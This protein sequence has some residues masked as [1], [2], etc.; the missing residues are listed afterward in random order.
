MDQHLYAPS[1]PE[2]SQLERFATA[3][4]PETYRGLYLCGINW[5]GEDS[6]RMAAQVRARRSFFSDDSIDG[7]PYRTRILTW[8]ALWGR[9]LAR[10]PARAGPLERAISQ[11]NWL[12]DR[13]K[14]SEHRTQPAYLLDHL[15]EF[16]DVCRERNPRVILLLG[17]CLGSAL[18]RALTRPQ[19]RAAVCAAFGPLTRAPV[20]IARNLP[21]EQNFRLR[22]FDFAR[23]RLLCLPH[24]TGAV[25]VTNAQIARYGPEVRA[26]LAYWRA[27]GTA[28]QRR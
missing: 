9:P 18:E 5:G 14:R 8:F 28:N 12:S 11:T 26:A 2:N 1:P 15:D 25:G 27:G 4:F 24:P 7:Y 22:T 3:S 20:V 21:G 19:T 13:S 6:D 17:S 23:C 16:L 10:E